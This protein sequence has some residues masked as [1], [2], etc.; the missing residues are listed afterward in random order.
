M[1]RSVYNIG[2]APAVDAAPS[3][4]STHAHLRA[5][6][7]SLVPTGADLPILYGGSVK[8]ANAGEIMAIDHVDGVLVG[9]AS[10]DAQEFWQIFVAG[11]AAKAA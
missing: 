8:A 4:A 2:T 1:A 11:R 7:K 5:K 9:G 6:L 10:L 3:I